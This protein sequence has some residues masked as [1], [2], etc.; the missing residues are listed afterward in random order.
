MNLSIIKNIPKKVNKIIIDGANIA[1]ASRIGKKADINNLIILLS[2][3]RLLQKERPEMTFEIICDAGLKR[4]IT[5]P[6]RY[7]KWVRNGAIKQSSAKIK[8]DEYIIE[9]M[10]IFDG[11]IMLISNDL[12]REYSEIDQLEHRLQFGFVFIFGE[13][14][15]K[16][17]AFLK[18]KKQKTS[19]L[20]IKSAERENISA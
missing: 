5:E 4:S 1:Y 11:S 6:Q 7:E 8:A 15:L 14:I 16:E 2:G 18:L 3:L 20:S 17:I 19:M 13:L 10:Q 12:M 9:V